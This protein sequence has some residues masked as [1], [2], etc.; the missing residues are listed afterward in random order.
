M[1][2]KQLV[3]GTRMSRT[4]F[5]SY[6]DFPAIRIGDVD[7]VFSVADACSAKTAAMSFSVQTE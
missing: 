6:G 1:R 4:K 2:Y 5:C 7:C 3:F